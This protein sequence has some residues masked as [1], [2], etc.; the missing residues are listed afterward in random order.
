VADKNSGI[1]RIAMRIL[2][3]AGHEVLMVGNGEAAV[4][5]IAEAPPDL[6]MAD[7]FMPGYNGYEVCQFVKKD[8]RFSHIPV[9]LLYGQYDPFDQKEAQRV[10]ADSVLQK[11]FANPD[12]MLGM[13]KSLIDKSKSARPQQAA[14]REGMRDAHDAFRAAVPGHEDT[15]QLT[16]TDVRAMTSAAPAAAPEPDYDDTAQYQKKEIDFSLSGSDQPIGFDEITETPAAPPSAFRGAT[17]V[18]AAPEVYIPD[19]L[20]PAAGAAEA[21]EEEPLPEVPNF[22]GIESEPRQPTPDM[23]PIKVE[24]SESPEPLELVTD[25][26]SAT[27]DVVIQRDPAL[28]S[29]ADE[30]TGSTGPSIA[31]TEETPA[32]LT[33]NLEIAPP[34][35][36]PASF[37]VPAMEPAMAMAASPPEVTDSA[38]IA[39]A[40]GMA[41][42][43]ISGAA[44][45]LEIPSI[46]PP[47]IEEPPPPPPEQLVPP[48]GTPSAELPG[49]EWNPN[50]ATAE[51]EPPAPEA[52]AEPSGVPGV[53]LDEI[54][55]KVVGQIS[56]EITERI[57]REV[58]RRIAES[59]LGKK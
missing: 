21:P 48:S 41:G 8:D 29:S 46:P 15:Q 4:Q 2:K 33:G 12:Q 36:A 25:D 10:R 14:G 51:P 23:P 6:V 39:A 18:P 34:P 13:I 31:A 57:T 17:A 5:K 47:A 40:A 54:V 55:R 50:A 59:G 37:E 30:F 52:G 32:E 7:I 19:T 56:P 27:A 22:G 24:F 3:G 28:A 49:L 35:P 58:V 45:S 1:Q 53:D 43:E 38:A 9:V 44:G 11:P 42:P 26:R 16:E 20:A